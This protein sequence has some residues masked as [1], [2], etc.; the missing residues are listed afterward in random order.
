ML[1]YEQCNIGGKKK[2][3]LFLLKSTGTEELISRALFQ[4]VVVILWRIIFP[5]YVRVIIIFLEIIMS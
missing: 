5:I 1:K 2:R 4:T 3:N